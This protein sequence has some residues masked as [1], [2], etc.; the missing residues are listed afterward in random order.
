MIECNEREKEEKKLI[1]LQPFDPEPTDATG[2]FVSVTEGRI[3]WKI[4]EKVVIPA[5][6]SRDASSCLR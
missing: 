3:H 4:S 5:P 1:T 2:V 6:L